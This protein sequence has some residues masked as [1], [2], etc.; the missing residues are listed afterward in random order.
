MAV[1]E[2]ERGELERKKEQVKAEAEKEVYEVFARLNTEEAKHTEKKKDKPAEL[3]RSPKGT[4][5]EV[6]SSNGIRLKHLRL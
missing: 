3:P 2:R 1:D 5:A 6:S 4:T